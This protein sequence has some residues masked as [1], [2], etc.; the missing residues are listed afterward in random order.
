MEQNSQNSRQL[1]KLVVSLAFVCIT[2]ATDLPARAEP[3]LTFMVSKA[4]TSLKYRTDISRISLAK[5]KLELASEKM[6]LMACS[7]R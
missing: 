2:D 7:L 4:S 5:A 3:G 1:T 6:T